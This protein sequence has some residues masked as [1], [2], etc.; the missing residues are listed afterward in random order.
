MTTFAKPFSEKFAELVEKKYP[1]IKLVFQE[2]TY[3]ETG[4][5]YLLMAQSG[6]VPD[7]AYVE[8]I[9]SNELTDVDALMDLT[10]LISEDIIADLPTAIYDACFIEGKGLTSIFWDI[11]PYALFTSSVLS[12]E[13]G[14]SGPPKTLDEFEKMVYAIA[15]L[16]TD[17][18][19]NK[20]WGTNIAGKSDIHIPFLLAPW[21]YNNGAQYFDKT[22]K[23]VINSPEAVEVITWFKKMYDD[24]VYGPIPIDRETNRTLFMEGDL[25]F[26]GEGP[27]QRGIWRDSSGLGEE[28]D[29]NWWVA[30]YPTADGTP[31]SSILHGSSAAIMNGAKHPEEAAKV[32]EM[33][34]ADPEVVLAYGELNGG[35]P[36]VKTI[37]DLPEVQ[38]DT[39][40]RAFIDGIQPGASFPF[41]EH[42]SKIN[43][44]AVEF[45][46]A[47]ESIILNDAPIQE[48]LDDLAEK[49]DE[50][51]AK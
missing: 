10:P 18:A 36:A 50:I 47:Y 16:G 12:T 37:Q 38:N 20:I 4:V 26:I 11:S 7:I 2:Q 30:P 29:N 25:G 41:I 14:F 43:E 8:Q 28:F 9:M 15:E 32:I 45:A 34:V 13:A 51:A 1:N 40:I 22:G 23:A 48:T 24:G 46:K 3:E 5:Q 27:W 31:G 42:P 6:D 35:I 39:Y 21:L 33:W 17:D 49:F 19:G 44:L